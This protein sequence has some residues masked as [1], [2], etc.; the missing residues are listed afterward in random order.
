M[1]H[2]CEKRA[3][4]KK[5]DIPMTPNSRVSVA[6]VVLVGLSVAVYGCA[7]A[8]GA[9][10]GAGTYAWQAGKLSFTTPN[11]VAPTHD[12]VLEAFDELNITV[13]Q[14]ETSQLGGTI[15]GSVPDTGEDV[16]ID[17]EP[18]ADNVT[19][20]DVRVGFFGDQ[21]KS[22]KIADAIRRNL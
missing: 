14:D 10:A 22:Q 8:A 1:A 15:K 17:L 11:A 2:I 19:K 16:T 13:V 9:A 6:L 18:Q 7:A 21:A 3:F 20:V 4:S 5:E 12:A